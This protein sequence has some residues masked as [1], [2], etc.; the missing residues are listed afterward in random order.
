MPHTFSKRQ[1]YKKLHKLVS[2]DR[3]MLDIQIVG[4]KCFVKYTK[5]LNKINTSKKPFSLKGIIKA[6][7][8]NDDDT[9]LQ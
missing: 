1:L 5:H 7:G 6:G 4:I 3:L 9:Y 2:S 8:Y